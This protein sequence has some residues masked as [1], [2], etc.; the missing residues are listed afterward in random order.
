MGVRAAQG[1]A[2]PGGKGLRV[3]NVD[4]EI[5]AL[6]PARPLPGAA[7]RQPGVQGQGRC[8]RR[9][10]QREQRGSRNR[11]ALRR[12]SSTTARRCAARTR[13][14]DESLGACSK[15]IRNQ[16]EYET[17]ETKPDLRE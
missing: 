5:M 16:P 15:L 17:Y 12:G 1:P 9:V 3:A 4:V 6:G 2:R 8:P 7:S 13:Q 11:R 10:T 14:L